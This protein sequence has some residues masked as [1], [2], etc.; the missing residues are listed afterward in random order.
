MSLHSLI[1]LKYTFFSI[2]FFVSDLEYFYFST[3]DVCVSYVSSG[4]AYGYRR[5]SEHNSARSSSVCS[6]SGRTW[7]AKD[8]DYHLYTLDVFWPTG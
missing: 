4:T 7:A 5:W 1:Y 8:C 6:A 2:Y 3:Q